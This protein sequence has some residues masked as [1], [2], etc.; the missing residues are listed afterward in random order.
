MSQLNQQLILDYR[1]EPEYTF[2]NFV[3]T[4]STEMAHSAA[5][6]VAQEND[7]K[8]SPFCIYGDKGVGKTHLLRA[9]G[10]E[11]RSNFKEIEII[12]LDSKNILLN[13]EKAK[14]EF[15]MVDLM[16]RFSKV[17][18]L[19]IDDIDKLLMESCLDEKIFHLY[20]HLIK[21]GK[22]L[23]FGSS[24]PPNQLDFSDEI[25]SRLQSG[26][27]VKIEKMNDEDK[28]KVIK[29]LSKDFEVFIPYDV[30]KYIL[31]SAPRDFK[32][33]YNI[34]KQINQLSLETK[35]KITLSLA[36]KTLK[37]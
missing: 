30:I 13:Q 16:G 4:P 20:N 32:S 34:V 31:N 33:I 29:K 17:S 7:R 6:L 21:R 26:L 22:Q 3:V 36:K 28:Q 23:V 11:A 35:K 2:N 12:Y 24:L 14:N 8:Y 37:M 15:D 10:N 18:F 1:F 25:K 5:V 19:I 27:S 9:I